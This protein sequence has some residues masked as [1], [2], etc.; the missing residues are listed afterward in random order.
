MS[1]LNDLLADLVFLYGEETGQ[2]TFARVE[3]SDRTISLPRY[4]IK[5]RSELSQ[6]DAILITYGDQVQKPGEAAAAYPG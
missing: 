4:P 1:T 3:G 6:R 2:A 5:L